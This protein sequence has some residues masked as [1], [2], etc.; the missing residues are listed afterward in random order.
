M[1]ARKSSYKK[2]DLV[3]IR[4]TPVQGGKKSANIKWLPGCGVKKTLVAENH[5]RYVAKANPELVLHPNNIK[6]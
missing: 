2:E 1:V 5:F 6:F 3:D 4:V